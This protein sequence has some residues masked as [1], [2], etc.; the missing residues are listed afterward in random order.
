MTAL[1]PLHHLP[2]CL[3]L[4]LGTAAAAPV[5]DLDQA[6][7]LIRT[8][9]AAQ[10][11]GLL[12]PHEF[13]LAGDNRY[14]YLLGAAAVDSG[15]PDRATI[16]LE[17]VLAVYPGYAGARLEIARAYFA[18][19]DL[20]RARREFET[21]LQQAPP[22]AARLTIERHL[23]AIARL[24][25]AQR[26]FSASWVEWSLGHDS[27]VNNSTSQNQVFVDAI[28]ATATLLPTSIKTADI[29]S[30]LGGGWEI[31]HQLA[32]KTTVFAGVEARLR[33]NQQQSAF[34]TSNVDSRAGVQLGDVSNQL[35]LTL[36]A[37]RFYVDDTANR[38]GRGI[39]AEWRVQPQPTRQVG[40]FAQYHQLRYRTTELIGNNSNLF[41][42]GATWLEALGR[43]VL[44]GS[45]YAGNEVSSTGQRVDGDRR[46]QGARIGVQHELGPGVESFA[47]IGLQLSAYQ[48]ENDNFLRTRFDRQSDLTLGLNWHINTDWTLRP[49]LTVIRNASNIAIYDYQRA[50]AMLTL[51]YNWR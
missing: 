43:T 35:R 5:L 29:Y 4:A 20:L 30:S 19:G 42:G 21:L 31:R 3:L 8:G 17:R 39:S 33:R 9:Q 2:L 13:D 40:A 49:Q 10:A 50:D 23:E 45:V 34:D 38:D 22:E 12:A 41:I 6:E 24:A 25:E 48:R 15:R 51:R 7:H 46:I 11:Y 28:N 18:L 26:T 27:N 1:T 16:A 36:N 32:A 37:G 47:S 44:F 14:D